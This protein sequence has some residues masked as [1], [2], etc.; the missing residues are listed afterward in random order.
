MYLHTYLPTEVKHFESWCIPIF[1]AIKA[2]QDI[3]K[4]SEI[5]F[6]CRR[7]RKSLNGPHGS[8]GGDL[9]F[10]VLARRRKRRETFL[11]NSDKQFFPKSRKINLKIVLSNIL[12]GKVR[13]ASF[14]LVFGGNGFKLGT[15]QIAGSTTIESTRK[16]FSMG[17]CPDSFYLHL[18]LHLINVNFGFTEYPVPIFKLLIMSD[19]L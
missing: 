5:I 2:G 12:S 4:A 7:S 10:S 14:P 15:Q 13:Y 18:L 8:A 16:C 1:T 17:Q 6:V 19:L 9:L 11:N 3:D